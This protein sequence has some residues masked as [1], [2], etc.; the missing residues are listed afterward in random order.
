MSTA[1]SSP[2]IGIFGHDPWRHRPRGCCSLWAPGCAGAVAHA[3]GTPVVLS[4]PKAAQPWD[5]ALRGLDGIVFLGDEALRGRAVLQERR[6]CQVCAR[7]RLPMLAIDHGL[8][9]L[10]LTCGGTIHLD[11]PRER[12]EAL[13]HRHRLEEGLRHAIVAEPDTR[14]MRVYGEG[15]IIVNSEHR[16]AVAQVGRGFRISARALDG[17][18]EA[19]E[20]ESDDWYAIGVQ[21][22][23]ASPTAS[24]LDIQ[25]FRSF[26]TAAAERREQPAAARLVAA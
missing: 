11:L 23:P 21:W 14:L 22:Q 26:V 7:R 15:E 4:V 20:P 12:P 8:H 19:I 24:A 1:V 13:Q 25:L 5:D 16:G 6:L 2:H 17:V 3:G 9:V 18:I 10:N